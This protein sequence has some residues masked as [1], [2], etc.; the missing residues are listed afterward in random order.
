M[1][2]NNNQS[3]KTVVE[4]FII[5]ET[6]ELLHDNEAL[7]KWNEKINELGLSGQ[8]KVLVVKDKS[9]VPFLWMNSSIISTFE[10]LCPTKVLIENYDKTPIPLEILELVSMSKKEGYFYKIEIW[11]NEQDIDPVCIGFVKD[12]S[13]N[14]RE[15]WYVNHYANKYLLGRWADVKA[16][17]DSLVKKAKAIFTANTL[18]SYNKEIRSYQRRIEDIESEANSKFGGAMP[19]ETLLPF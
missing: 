4:T 19:D 8:Q 14:E 3:M 16:S 11:Y 15:E 7:Q 13:K 1:T 18:I 5:E 12:T 10:I 6:S 2:T 9:P 17:L